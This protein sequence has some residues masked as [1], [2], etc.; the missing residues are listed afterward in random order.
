MIQRRCG[1]G[2]LH[3][4]PLPFRVGGFLQRQHLERDE[5]VEV[6]VSRALCTIAHAA[7]AELRFDSVVADRL[8][9]HR[10]HFMRRS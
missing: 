10:S 2:F 8:A 6:W 5:T 1:L 7:F 4:A 3:Q 9:N